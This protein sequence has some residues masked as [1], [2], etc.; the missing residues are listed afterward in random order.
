MKEV[1]RQKEN[2]TSIK[3]SSKIGSFWIIH[4][5]TFDLRTLKPGQHLS[6]SASDIS[7][8]VFQVIQEKE[9]GLGLVGACNNPKSVILV[10][11]EL[12]WS[13]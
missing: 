4:Q 13:P 9:L 3:Y 12:F 7:R 1:Y 6:L 10:D 11:F 8:I 2:T 5:K